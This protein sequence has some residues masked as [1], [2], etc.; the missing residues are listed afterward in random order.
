MPYTDEQLDPEY[1]P[2]HDGSYR[3]PDA[4]LDAIQGRIEAVRARLAPPA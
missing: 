4:M 2:Y 1:P 3:T